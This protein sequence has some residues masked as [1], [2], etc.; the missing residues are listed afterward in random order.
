M[1][2]I[3]RLNPHSNA[4]PRASSMFDLAKAVDG[5]LI[6]G[7]RWGDDYLLLPDGGNMELVE[8]LMG[9]EGIFFERVDSLPGHL[10]WQ[11]T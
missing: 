10:Q 2:A 3:Y 1:Q 6:Q 4:R 7:E 5:R 11:L 9:E 8:C